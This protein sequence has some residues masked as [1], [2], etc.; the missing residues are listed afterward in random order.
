MG[1]KNKGARR[2]RKG[3][4]AGKR[5]A[6]AKPKPAARAKV[7]SRAKSKAKAKPGARA[8]AKGNSKR[9]ATRRARRA[10]ALPPPEIDRGAVLRRARS[11]HAEQAAVGLVLPPAQR[12]HPST[13]GRTRWRSASSAKAHSVKACFTRR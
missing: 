11:E 6:T 4:P 2:K 7:K 1:R 8:K 3:K 13:S 12:F 9:A 5:K 10:P